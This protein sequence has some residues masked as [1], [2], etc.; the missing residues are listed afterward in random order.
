MP[1][2]GAIYNLFRNTH[3]IVN[4]LIAVVLLLFLQGRLERKEPSYFNASFGAFR[5]KDSAFGIRD[6]CDKG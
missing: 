5:Y 2:I 3:A 1:A 4:T 6:A